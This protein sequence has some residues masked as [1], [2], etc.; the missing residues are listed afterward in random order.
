MDNNITI[1][2]P[3]LIQV[4]TITKDVIVA[5][6]AIITVTIAW[7]GLSAWKKEFIDKRKIELAEEVLGKLYEVQDAI[8]YIRNPVSWTNEAKIRQEHNFETEDEIQALNKAYIIFDR[9]NKKEKVFSE[10]KTLKYR[11][12]SIFGKDIDNNFKKIDEIINIIFTS[13]HMLGTYYWQKENLISLSNKNQQ[14]DFKKEK[15]LHEE[16]IWKWK[17]KDDKIEKELN[18]ILEKFEKILKP[19]FDIK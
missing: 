5:I 18:E 12:M 13:A 3:E 16:N 1:L 8:F 4:A 17:A 6:V 7:K 14:D 11:A 19:Y 2:T 9:Y 10:F 15:Q